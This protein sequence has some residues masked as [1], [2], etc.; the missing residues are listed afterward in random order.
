MPQCKNCQQDFVITPEDKKFYGKIGVP[1][2]TLCPICRNQRRLA[3]RNERTFYQIKSDLSG[4]EI[5][6]V[7][8]ADP[9]RLASGEAG[10]KFPVYE[11]EEWWSDKWDPFA[12]GREIN[13]NRSIRE[14]IQELFLAVPRPALFNRNCVNSH[15]GNL[16]ESDLNCYYEVGSGWCEESHYSTVNIHCKNILDS[17]YNRKCEL[18]YYLINCEDCYNGVY[19]ENCH[20]CLETYFCYNCRG[21]S[22][23]F[24]CVN[25]RSAKYHWF[26]QP[27]SEAEF[28]HRLKELGKYSFYQKAK[29]EFLDF[30]KTNIH[31][32][33]N[34]VKCER[35]TGDYLTYC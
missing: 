33:A 4:K 35:A 10:K 22:N 2:P 17:H 29:Q 32:Y 15:Y 8:P 27:I 7:Y 25:L 16:Q 5:L 12:Y 20:N 28:K 3:W 11:Q 19:C 6:A 30:K 14:Q 23:C 18:S 26:N 31:L 24:G 13:W 9:P 21:C 1:E 34:L